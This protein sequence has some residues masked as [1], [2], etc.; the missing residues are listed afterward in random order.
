MAGPDGFA[1]RRR[2]RTLNE[3]PA[4]GIHSFKNRTAEL[5]RVRD[6]LADPAVRIITLLGRR[7]IGK[8]LLAVRA[9]NSVAEGVWPDGARTE[10]VDAVVYFGQRTT[11]IT[12]ERIFFDC[13][14]LLDVQE[15]ERL[16]RIWASGRRAADKAS[17]LFDALA[18]LQV[19]LLLD[20][21]EDLLDEEDHFREPELTAMVQALLTHEGGPRLLI[22]SQVPLALPSQFLRAERRIVLYD[23]LPEQD[24]VDLL[25]ELDPDGRGGIRDADDALLAETAERV[26][27][28]PRGLELIAGA[29]QDD[30]N[31]RSLREW[32]RDTA[33]VTGI[34]DELAQRR[35][36]QL[37]EDHRLVMDTLA[38][39]G[40][41]VVPEAVEWVLR[42]LAPNLQVRSVLVDLAR[43][44]LVR[45]DRQ[46]RTYALLPM[47][48]DIAR[49]DLARRNPR[50]A[51]RLHRRAAD[52]YARS[53]KPREEWRSPPD[54]ALQRRELEHR[55]QAGDY[56][57]A[58]LLL[59]RFADFLVWQG[60]A[61]AVLSICT[62][63]TGRLTQREAR[64]AYL[65]AYGHAYFLI[66]PLSRAAELL[67][68]AE[69]L[70]TGPQDEAC[71]QRILFLLGDMDRT[72]GRLEDAVRRYR[73]SADIAAGL[74][75]V[76][77]QAHALLGLSLSHSYATRPDLG[78]DVAAELTRLSRDTGLPVVRAREGDALA[79]A[80]VTMQ[81][82][83]RAAD[84]VRDAIVAYEESGNPEGLG[85][86]WNSLGIARVGTGEPASALDAF[87]TGLAVSTQGDMP[88]PEALCSF[89]RAW[90]LWRIGRSADAETAARQALSAYRRC[91][92]KDE[93]AAAALCDALAAHRAGDQA[94]VAQH[95]E[96]CAALVAGN[97]DLC[98]PEWFRSVAE[99]IRTTGS[100]STGSS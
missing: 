8:S 47:D 86:A 83:P 21:L 18:S 73:S 98:P 65:V 54:V 82:W 33:A 35:Y 17:E 39:F 67:R 5:P 81:D 58:A 61:G 38:I 15:A 34:V 94:L 26:Y 48:T 40:T 45:A 42:P 53:A 6:L 43:S 19:L 97:P 2:A 3:R 84:A 100:P 28:V 88:R 56:D 10:P 52:W 93:R 69:T 9:A 46:T 90:T 89:N 51:R 77:E 72:E 4:F 37:D 13:L 57:E 29:L 62:S 25:R 50:L 87:D 24:S 70:A 16:H 7:G 14:R 11:G 79:C 91:G 27:G 66:G 59:D 31:M 23:G 49:A 96:R 32:L 75:M 92:A 74:G 78:L 95:L 41:P 71:L 44:F 12:F 36:Q 22:T 55:M 30:P 76:E 60:S 20:N 85:F 68:E 63:L 64:L 1:R 99:R 80:Y